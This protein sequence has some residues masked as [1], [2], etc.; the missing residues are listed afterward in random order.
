MSIFTSINDSALTVLFTAWGYDMTALELVAVI[1][2]L[3]GVWLG[4]TG[5]QIMW[6]WWGLS[7]ALYGWLFFDFQLYASAL[8]QIVFIAASIWGWFG[9]G[10]SGAKSQVLSWRNRALV[11]LIGILVWL[12]IT[13]VLISWGA[14]AAKPDAFGLVFSVIAQIIMVLEFR[15]NWILWFVVD[16]AYSVLYWQQDLKFTSVLYIVFTAIALRG[17]V[18]W[19]RLQITISSRAGY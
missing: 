3:I 16:G 14:A 9:W 2:S 11:L 12:A 19:Q 15:E 18:A 8:L 5:K 13:P 1:T 6:P 10:P 17:W 7:S 4:T